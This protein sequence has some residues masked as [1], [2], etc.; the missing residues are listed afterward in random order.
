DFLRRVIKDVRGTA[1]TTLEEKYFAEDKDPKKR[2]KLL[3]TLLK[4]GALA[5]KLGDDWKKKMLAAPGAKGNTFRYELRPSLEY[6]IPVNPKMGGV[7]EYE[8][9]IDPKHLQPLKIDPKYS[10]PLK[11]DPKNLG[12]WQYVD[13]LEFKLETRP[14]NPKAP[15]ALKPPA[16]PQA[17]K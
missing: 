15:D 8:L 9:Q 7:W 16:A 4:D 10:Q 3:D 2:E 6:A 1:P 12:S 11:I 14:V 5:K 17:D 13:P